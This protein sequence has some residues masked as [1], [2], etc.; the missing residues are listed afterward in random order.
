MWY[1]PVCIV[2]LFSS[3]YI[4]LVGNIPYRLGISNLFSSQET[5]SI[6]PVDRD[7]E[8]KE[9][10]IFEGKPGGSI[11]SRVL[12]RNTTDQ[13][14]VVDV[15]PVDSVKDFPRTYSGSDFILKA[16]FDQMF[17]IGKWAHVKDEKVSV[18]AYD[19]VIV[20]FTLTIPVDTPF[21]EY[22]GAIM[23]DKLDSVANPTE[24][25]GSMVNLN[26]VY[27]LRI[28]LKVTDTPQVREVMIYEDTIAQNN[29][30]VLLQLSFIVF[31]F[32]LLVF[33]FWYGFPRNKI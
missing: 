3:I 9:W 8:F 24:I 20:P 26:F 19:N 12:I 23:V 7:E 28:F 21:G 14:A 1:I 18:N 33:L 25:Q 4:F 27:G 17:S 6:S 29:K 11:E 32:L 5:V 2:F 15:Y 10:L 30:V 31:N 22:S 13:N 16:R